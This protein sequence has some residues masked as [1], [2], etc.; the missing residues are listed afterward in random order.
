[1]L[2]FNFIC[3]IMKIVCTWNYVLSALTV[4]FCYMHL[5]ICNSF[6]YLRNQVVL[7]LYGWLTL[8]KITCKQN[9]L[10]VAT[11]T[12]VPRKYWY[13][14]IS[15]SMKFKIKKV[16]LLNVIIFVF[17]C[18]LF[19]PRCTL[20]RGYSYNITVWFTCMY[21]LF[22]ITSCISWSSVHCRILALYNW[23]KGRIMI[24]IACC[25]YWYRK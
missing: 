22:E 3:K 14:T 8:Y 15:I 17:Q 1:M 6:E 24:C 7:Q 23:H 21:F 16:S 25:L 2:K 5:K 20:I 12:F 9:T 19:M 11:L 4:T 10:L 13:L 18:L